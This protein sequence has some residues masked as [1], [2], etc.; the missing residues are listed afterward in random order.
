M[1]LVLGASALLAGWP[2]LPASQADDGTLPM[3]KLQATG[4]KVVEKREEKKELPGI[5]PYQNLVRVVQLVHFRL[6]KDDQV[7]RCIAEYDSQ[8]DKYT[9]ACR[10]GSR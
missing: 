6:E 7:M 5:A 1:L 10:A 8:R 4:W 9:E 3:A 2:I